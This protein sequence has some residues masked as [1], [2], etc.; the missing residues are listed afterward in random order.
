MST[1][2]A[3]AAVKYDNGILIIGDTLLSYGNMARWHSISRIRVGGTETGR[4]NGLLVAGSGNYSDFQQIL[5]ALDGQL[6]D[7]YVEEKATMSTAALASYLSRWAYDRHRQGKALVVTTVLAGTRRDAHTGH[8]VP[9][10]AA[11][12]PNGMVSD[13]LPFVTT[14][15]LAQGGTAL[16]EAAAGDESLTLDEAKA[17]LREVASLHWKRDAHSSNSFQFGQL[18][19]TAEGT[20]TVSVSEPFEVAADWSYGKEAAPYFQQASATS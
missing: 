4:P 19:I 2:G 17:L 12:R 13:T 3:I 14:G 10:L 8:T 11:V 1:V 15:F 5:T 20:S 16:Y 9:Y 6:N 7:E 18:S